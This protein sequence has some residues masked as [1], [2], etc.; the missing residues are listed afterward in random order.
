MNEVALIRKSTLPQIV[1]PAWNGE[2]GDLRRFRRYSV[3]RRNKVFH[4]GGKL[5]QLVVSLP[6]FRITTAGGPLI[7]QRF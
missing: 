3:T 7:F 4:S 6:S 1:I 2:C 5:P